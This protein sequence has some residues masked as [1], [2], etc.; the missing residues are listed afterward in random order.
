VSG[1]SIVVVSWN[2][3][4]LALR[5]LAAAQQAA[6]GFSSATG[7]PVELVLVDNG[8]S[9]GT[10]DAVR[11]AL[12]SVRIVALP[13]NRGFAGGANAGCAAAG[14]DLLLLL[15]SDA[16][17]DA[18]ALIACWRHLD[19]HPRTG[20]V[21][22]Q[23]LHE[24][25]RLQNSAHAFPAWIDE[26]VPGFVIDLVAPRR[27]P[28]KRWVGTAPIA[29]DAVQGAALLVRRTVLDAV[30][31]FDEGYFFYLEETDLCWRARRAGFGVDL[32]PAARVVHASGASSKRV[33]AIA[34][35]I[36]YHRSLYRFL[37]AHRGVGTSRLAAAVR[38]LRGAVTV[39]G[40][41][42]AA[43]VSASARRRFVERRALLDWHLR[44]RPPDPS[45]ARLGGPIGATAG[46]GAA[47][48]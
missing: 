12:P 29:V 42:P 43:L 3:R 10:A 18:S 2:T 16:R 5:C 25:G 40:L 27:R 1:L 6:S 21:G 26:L 17:V 34:S 11:A 28:A 30:G 4:A 41:A 24:D 46:P 20:V 32:V 38:T 9:D 22:P 37:R 45:L 33:A 44:G 15:N 39:A 13:R 8:S 36:E 14:G 35:R 31:G 7:T 48:G 47:P 19:A 23:L